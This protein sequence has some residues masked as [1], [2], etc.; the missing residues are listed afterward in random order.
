MDA[1]FVKIDGL[2]VFDFEGGVRGGAA[3]PAFGVSVGAWA[4]AAVSQIDV[5]KVD[6]GDSSDVVAMDVGCQRRLAA[7]LREMDPADGGGAFDFKIVVV[8]QF[9]IQET[10]D[11]QLEVGEGDVRNRDAFDTFRAVFGND[12]DGRARL[13][14]D[15]VGECAVAHDA[16]ADADAQSV[17]V[18]ALEYAVRDGD[19]LAGLRRGQPRIVAAEGDAVIGRVD[20]AIGYGDETAA[21]DV[22]AVL[23]GDVDVAVDVDVADGGEFAAMEEACP[24]GG[25]AKIDIVDPDVL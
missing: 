3:P 22:D 6:V 16:A 13:R 23:I 12:A 7:D 10:F 11:I 4:A 24:V 15:D 19:H 25:V 5:G 20:D 8:V 18:A 9:Q 17:G 1:N 14:D 2:A 21:V